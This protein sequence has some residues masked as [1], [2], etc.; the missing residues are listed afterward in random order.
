MYNCRYIKLKKNPWA[1]DM[2]KQ[3]TDSIVCGMNIGSLHNISSLIPVITKMIL[4]AALM[5]KLFKN[6]MHIMTDG[7]LRTRSS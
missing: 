4:S 1:I 6:C 3:V 2:N 5:L 7:T